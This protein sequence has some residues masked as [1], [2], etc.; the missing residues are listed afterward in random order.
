MV[1]SKV[2]DEDVE[3]AHGMEW[4]HKS[5]IAAINAGVGLN[6]TVQ[7]YNGQLDFGIIA[8]RELMP[9]VW[10]PMD[11]LSDALQG[12]KGLAKEK[13]QAGV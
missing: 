10:E 12:L 6:I 1:V 2:A 4:D 8:C 13:R 9:D 11:Y 3:G 5:M 7:S